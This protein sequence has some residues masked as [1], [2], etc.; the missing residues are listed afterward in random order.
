MVF[1]LKSVIFLLGLAFSALSLHYRDKRV[2]IAIII[3]C[4]FVLRLELCL[5]PFL[6]EWDERYHALV[7][8]NFQRS[9]WLKPVLYIDT[10]IDFAMD[11]W[12]AN[13]VWLHKQPLALWIMSWSLKIMGNT[14]LAVRVPSLLFSTIGVLLTFQISKHLFSRQTALLA[15]FFH[16]INGFILEITAGRVATDHVD[17]LFAFLVECGVFLAVLDWKTSSEKAQHKVFIALCVGMLCGLAILCKWLTG[18]IILLLYAFVNGPFKLKTILSTALAA[19]V[20]AAI[21]MPWQ[22]YA[23]TH[24][25]AEYA[26]EMRFNALH[27]TTAIEGHGHPWWW[28]LN[29][30]RIQWNELVYLPLLWLVYK[31]VKRDGE[32]KNLDFIA[33]WV[34]VPYFIFS[35]AVTKMPAYVLFAAPAIF[36]LSAHY[37]DEA[38]KYW[39]PW[40][41]SAFFA[42]F[43]LLSIRYSIERGKPFHG[44]QIEQAKMDQIN[45]MVE[46]CRNE[47]QYPKVVVFNLRHNIEFMFF[48]DAI[49]YPNY[50]TE[51]ETEK[52]KKEGYTVLIAK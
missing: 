46:R 45:Q 8:K 28:Y 51:A 30:A 9:S 43:V 5:D 20:A 37:L 32:N 13:Q 12:T 22:I 21:A 1:S 31:L 25:P 11:N 47:I 33:C 29:Q 42:L 27:F 24:F 19:A 50:P 15:A 23:S 2:A 26:H 18:L 52:L 34:F 4:A 14:L 35:V 17:V 16:A 7:A 10:P 3:F 39:K 6:H 36:I 41:R 49:A 48:S 44:D 38:I 40:I